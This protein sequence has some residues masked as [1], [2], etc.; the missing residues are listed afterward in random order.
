MTQMGITGEVKQ[1]A[2][3]KKVLSEQFMSEL[4][5]S[6]SEFRAIQEIAKANETG[7]DD[8]ICDIVHRYVHLELEQTVALNRK[9]EDLMKELRKQMRSEYDDVWHAVNEED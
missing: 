2:T 5:L 1:T 6:K 8:A 3:R 9:Q 4:R 7:F